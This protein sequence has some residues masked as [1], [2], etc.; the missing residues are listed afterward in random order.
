MKFIY[1][2]SSQF[3]RIILESLCRANLL[4]QLVIT[5]PDRPKG[6][7]LV[8][9]PTEI[10]DFSLKAKFSLI[11]PKTLQSSSLSEKISELKP[12]LF[13]VADYGK[14]IPI[15]LLAVPKIAAIGVH[16]SLLPRYRGPAP[17]NW[18][19]INGEKETGVTIFKMNSG[20]DSGE[21]ILQRKIKIFDSDNVINL[22]QRLS[23][24]AAL[25]L[26]EVLAGAEKG[27]LNFIVQ[28]EKLSSFAP[29]LKKQDGK[30][31]WNKDALSIF[32]LIRATYG[33]PSAYTNFKG[34]VLKVIEA[35]V[36]AQLALQPTATVIGIDKSGISVTTGGGVL[37]IKRIKPEGKSEM[38]AYS[39]ILG[40]KIKPGDKF[41]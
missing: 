14:I 15:S 40:H 25:A 12:D 27:K 35:E 26:L 38:D 37:K 3:S 20:V 17:I 10:S 32:N 19:L 4:P 33:W 36:M 1:F 5:Q 6:R 39:F 34:K 24:E 28:D 7:G 11:K 13:I 16:P 29:K 30:I 8:I 41:E 2:G 9:W 23:Q 31:N 18:A 22:T 21:I